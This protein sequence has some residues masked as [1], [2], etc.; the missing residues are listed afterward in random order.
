MKRDQ[1]PALGRVP[2]VYCC[3][4]RE[5]TVRERL[6]RILSDPVRPV[7]DSGRFRP[8]PLLVMLGVVAVLVI[9]TFLFFSFGEL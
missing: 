5:E 2:I 8:N 7:S 1:Q 3:A 9:A 4:A 6:G